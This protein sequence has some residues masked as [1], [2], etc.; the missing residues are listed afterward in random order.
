MEIFWTS[1]TTS[2]YD[3]AD[4]GSAP[5][6]LLEMPSDK[7]K[8][9]EEE[10]CRL[11]ILSALPDEVAIYLLG[12]GSRRSADQGSTSDG[13]LMWSAWELRHVVGQVCRNWRRL[14]LDA[15]LMAATLH[16]SV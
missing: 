1:A 2:S 10:A 14:A 13:L 9:V 8:Q 12:G 3:S 16:R 7:K 4:G 11:D 6:T 5:A 15:S